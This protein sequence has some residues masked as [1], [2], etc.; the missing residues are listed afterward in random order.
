MISPQMYAEMIR[1]CHQREIAALDASMFHLDGPGAVKHLDAIL[2]LE[3]LN[4]VQWVRGAGGGSALDWIELYQRIQAAGKCMEVK[5]SD[6]ATAVAMMEH[7]HPE[8]VWF[9]V[10]SEYTPDEARAFLDTVQRWA[11]GK[12]V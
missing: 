7:L 4:G 1:P 2:T 11:A 12:R 6:A 9:D 3:G 5:V 10:G 8:G